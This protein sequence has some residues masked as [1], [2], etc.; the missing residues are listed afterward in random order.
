MLVLDVGRQEDDPLLEQPGEDVERPLAARRLLD[1]HR[2][3]CHQ[4]LL[5]MRRTLIDL[6][7]ELLRPRRRLIFACSIRKS[8]VLRSRSVSRMPSRS[9]LCSI[10]RRTAGAR[11]LAGLGQPLHLGVHVRVGRRSP[12]PSP[13]WPR[14]GAPAARALSAPGRSSASE[15]LVVPADRVR[16]DA[17]PAQPLAGVLDLVADL[18]ARPAL[19]GTV[20]VVA[21]RAPRP[22]P[23][24]RARGGPRRSRRPRAPVADRGPQRVER[25]EG[26][27]ARLGELVVE[28]RAASFSFTSVTVTRGLARL[29]AQRL[30]AVVVGE[31]HR[32][33]PLLAGLEADH[34]LVHLGQHAAAADHEGVAGARDAARAPRG[35]ACSRRPR[36]RRRAPARSTVTELARAARASC[37]SASVHLG[38]GHRLGR[39]LDGRRPV[40]SPSA[41]AGLIS[42]TAVNLRGAPSSSWTS[43]SSGSSTGPICVSSTRLPV[44]VGDQRLGHLLAHV[45]GE[46]Q[47]DQGRAGPC[48]GGS[49]AAAAR[50]A[51]GRRPLPRRPHVLLGRLDD[52][53]DACRAPVLRLDFHRDDRASVLRRGV[54][55]E[56]GVE[57][58]RVAPTGS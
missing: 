41:M 15:L 31:A 2:D 6:D 1:D 43:W 4:R 55:R 48:P 44:D 12:L 20:E 3:Q 5:A 21:A 46:V 24:P 53:A 54:V 27:R 58:P 13:R 30:V 35:A 11:P 52:R 40:Y 47:L 8:R 17:L 50:A 56:G 7:S 29:A 22:P 51:R 19:S 37:S 10:M 34:G 28:R 14:G 45:V 32:D 33:A 57:P 9:P 36:G 25:L 18:R 42:T 16:V 38:V 26:C 49:P 39:V 23:P